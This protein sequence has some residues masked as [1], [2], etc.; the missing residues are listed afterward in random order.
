MK[1]APKNTFDNISFTRFIYIFAVG[2][3]IIGINLS[4]F[5]TVSWQSNPA[6]PAELLKQETFAT[7]I[8][9]AAQT[10]QVPV[11][12][13]LNVNFVPDGNLSKYESGKQRAEIKQ[14]QTDF[15]RHY[16]SLNLKNIKQFDYI[17]YMAFEADANALRTMQKE[18][19]TASIQADE[20]A[21][22]ALAESTVMVGATAAWANGYSGS[23]Q[24]VAILDSGVDKTHTFL[25]GRVISE[26]CYSSNTASSTSFCPGGVTESTA[27]DSGLNCQASIAGCPHG[28]HV[29]GIAAGR[30]T[31]FS[32]V[33]KDANIIA[34]QMFSQFSSAGGCS[35]AF[36]ARYWTSDLIRALERV[37]TLANTTNNIVAVN[38]SLQTGQQFTS[39]CDLAH[40]ATKA[41]IDNL[42]S[43]NIA[44]IICSGNYSF[45][46]ALTAPACISTAISV[47]S[48]DDGSNGTIQN[49]V[50]DFSDSSPLLNLLA[51]GRW[52]SSSVPGNGYL[53]Y[54]GT[55]MAAPHVVGAFAVLR[56][57][58][59]TATIEQ[60][61]T[62]LTNTGQPITDLRNGVIKPL[63]KIDK[64]LNALTGTGYDFDGDS[65]TDI[66]I[67]R[68]NLGQWWYLRS[69]DNTNR[70][71]AFGTATDK[72]VPADYTGDGKTDLAFFR[73]STG[74]WFILRS[75]DSTFYG[76]PFGAGGDI[77]ASGDYDGDGRFDAAV[78]RPSDSTWYL[79]RSTAGTQILTFGISGDVP[80]P[81]A[82]VP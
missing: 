81:N 72:I 63:I 29:A 54:Q 36:C 67:F 82:F 28:T 8:A 27:P 26:A 37:R 17:P 5:A 38:L 64:A 79:N 3:L 10:E 66:S 11:I 77:P 19:L 39:N 31:S 13:G 56:Q 76:F 74:F 47:G 34:I 1:T 41:A 50:S 9:A 80:V 44:T 48:I 24:T 18:N 68:P 45:T 22:A 6:D 62:A 2:T 30:G 49:A 73:P 61:L 14:R 75:E 70:A 20:I 21:E 57:R 15:L 53:N 23:G 4:V 33:A 60:I 42:R 12:I 25:A 52:I 59:P 55:S 58:K 46:N 43:V 16:K 69:S 51:P 35:T 32:G 78:F 40:S 65:K 71:F 7:L